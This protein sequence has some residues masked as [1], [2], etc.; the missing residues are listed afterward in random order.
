MT[1]T[2]SCQRLPARILP[3]QSGIERD[4]INGLVAGVV[5]VATPANACVPG[6]VESHACA[7][8]C[9]PTWLSSG[10]IVVHNRHVHTSI[11]G[12]HDSDDSSN[13]N[14]DSDS[15]GAT[16]HGGDPFAQRWSFAGQSPRATGI[17]NHFIQF[18]SGRFV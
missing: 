18:A 9:G 3:G 4:S 12:C 1:R 10:A 7:D 13:R 6:S 17:G 15:F 14:L 5:G 2:T 16:E 11:N 8:S